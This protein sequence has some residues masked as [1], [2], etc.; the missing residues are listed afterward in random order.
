MEN[1]DRSAEERE[2]DRELRLHLMGRL[3]ADRLA[4]LL[5][6]LAAGSA[7][8]VARDIRAW[9][10]GQTGPATFREYLSAGFRR[11][12]ALAAHATVDADRRRAFFREVADALIEG[13]PSDAREALSRDVAQ[14]LSAGR[15]APPSAPAS[16]APAASPRRL[17]LIL[18]RL[19]S[20]AVE[21]GHGLAS[22]LLG[23]AVLTAALASSSAV[24]LEGNLQD[25]RRRGL[26]RG[27]DELFR[28][29]CRRCRPGRFRT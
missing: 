19:D 12:L 18:D 6:R 7:K 28:V 10:R 13:V 9:A 15:P 2:V 17:T 20:S 11:L 5:P 21:R 3:P 22:A 8:D 29:L 4:G 16:A 1:G 25:L 24:E 23:E 26:F 27:T 14:L